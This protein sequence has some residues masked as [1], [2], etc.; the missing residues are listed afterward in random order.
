MDGKYRGFDV[1][2][3][4]MNDTVDEEEYDCLKVYVYNGYIIMQKGKLLAFG[5]EFD[6]SQD[7]S[8][9]YDSNFQ[10]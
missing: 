8:V 7:V 1:K 9:Y 3:Y 4:T 2:M 10:S 6:I 5:T